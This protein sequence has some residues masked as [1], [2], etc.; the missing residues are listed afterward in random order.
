MVVITTR[1]FAMNVRG[2]GSFISWMPMSL[3]YFERLTK[4]WLGDRPYRTKHGS[5]T[6]VTFSNCYS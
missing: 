1:L 4:P 5:E 3:I 2:T 6:W